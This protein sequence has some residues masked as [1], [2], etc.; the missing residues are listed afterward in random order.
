[1]RTDEIAELA[2][3]VAETARIEGRPR[4]LLGLA[5]PPGAGKS[6]LARALV[7][8]LREQHGPTAAGYAPMDGFHLSNTQLD[9]LGLRARKGAPATFDVAGYAALLARLAT[10]E[11]EDVYCPDFDRSLD[12]P[13]AARHLVPAATALVVTEGNY[14]AVDLPG[15]ARA[16][17]SLDALWYLDGPSGELEERLV[18]RH[19]TGGL[20]RPAAAARVRA[21]DL[22]NA[23]LVR[24]SR[25]ARW[26]NQIVHWSGHV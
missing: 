6:T 1:M 3:Q 9:R 21:N 14:L 24:T 26:I 23:E 17:A 19:V 11:P 7:A 5:G 18:A 2:W 8:E 22:P 25:N 13:V 16:R 10:P 20:A 4:G 15:W 12:E